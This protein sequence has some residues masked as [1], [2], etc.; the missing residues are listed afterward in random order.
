MVEAEVASAKQAA[1]E[2]E[3]EDEVVVADSHGTL[4]LTNPAGTSKKESAAEVNNAISH[5]R[6]RAYKPCRNKGSS[7]QPF[8]Q[9]KNWQTR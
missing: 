2:E 7:H 9:L 3:A 1:E 8:L 5:T 6:K 4:A